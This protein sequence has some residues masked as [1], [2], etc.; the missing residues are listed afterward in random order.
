MGA[1]SFGVFAPQDELLAQAESQVFTSVVAVYKS[2]G[3]INQ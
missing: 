2:L 3:G 1:R